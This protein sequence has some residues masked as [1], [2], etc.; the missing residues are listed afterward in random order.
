MTGIKAI[1]GLLIVSL[2]TEALH[3]GLMVA[4]APPH[5]EIEPSNVSWKSHSLRLEYAATIPYA[6]TSHK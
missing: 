1:S 6:N 5:L 4:A 2:A 3:E